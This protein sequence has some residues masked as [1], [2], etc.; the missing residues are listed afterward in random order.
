MIHGDKDNIIGLWATKPFENNISNLKI[1]IFT[2]MG[3]MPMIE[4]TTGVVK[5]INDFIKID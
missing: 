2:N 4:D 5:E 3:H 1:K